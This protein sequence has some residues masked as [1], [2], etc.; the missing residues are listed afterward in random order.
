MYSKEEASK[1]RQQFWIT[2]GKYMKPIPSADGLPIN[3]VN[4]KT[5]LKH[6][7]F[8]MDVTQSQALISIAFTSPNPETRNVYY[9]QLGAL[10]ILFF[11]AVGEEWSWEQNAINEY[12][13]P[14]SCVSKTLDDV[15]I[16]N[17]SH[18]P[19]I[20]SFLKPRIVALDQFW[21][22]VKP[23]FEDISY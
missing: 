6:V 4:Y 8:K 14:F 1:L 16:F 10:K 7:C 19:S 3:W 12:G 13:N 2:Y 17:Q 21:V 11:D 20:I 18:W 15:N 5:G 22:E 23:L 9:E